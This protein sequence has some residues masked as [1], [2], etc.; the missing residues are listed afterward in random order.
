MP[1]FDEWFK[2]GTGY[3]PFPYQRRFA[4][5]IWD[6][7]ELPATELGGDVI[8]P[9]VRLSL[10]PMELGLCDQ[11]PFIGQ[12][13]WTERMIGLRDT[14]GPFRL[15]YLEAI[16]RAADMRASR[17]AEQRSLKAAVVEEATP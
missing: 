4:R 3:D 12:P 16:L 2:R 8:V 10:A 13:S 11:E 9:A 7:D 1:S 17:E 15:A 5:G 14:L 6:D